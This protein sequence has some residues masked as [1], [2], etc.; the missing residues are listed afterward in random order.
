MQDHHQKVYQVL[1]FV[2]SNRVD[3][4]DWG[5]FS[6][7]DWEHFTDMA[8]TEAVAP[9]VYTILN[10]VGVFNKHVISSEKADDGAM[11]WVVKA[12]LAKC[13]YHNAAFNAMLGNELDGIL[14]VL[15]RAGIPVILLKG[16]A[17]VKTV[18]PDPAERT[19]NDLDILVHRVHIR[20]AIR[21][22]HRAGYQRLIDNYIRYHVLLLGGKTGNISVE[23]H[24]S[25]VFN[26][27]RYPALIDWFWSQSHPLD[28]GN[29]FVLTLSPTAQLLYLA[30]HLVLQHGGLERLSWYYDLNLLINRFYTLIDWEALLQQ[31]SLFYLAQPLH[32]AL[33]ASRERFGFTLPEGF[34]E[35]LQQKFTSCSIQPGWMVGP[36]TDHPT[37]SV[38]KTWAGLSLADRLGLLRNILFP[39]PAYLRWRY[40]PRPTWLWPLWYIRRW[41]DILHDQH[42][43]W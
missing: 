29:P 10:Q 23:L 41:G 12:E 32:Q 22:L 16:A 28:M 7:A 31:A 39:R 19:M 15:T 1:H 20:P 14:A 5:A 40:H 11:P 38:R 4:V 8:Q 2:L 30:A 9:L 42:N 36:T 34:L 17:L 35:R 26:A 24:W 3:Q 18:Y 37:V 27:E 21:I 13:Y 43:E 25:L 33:T 6:S